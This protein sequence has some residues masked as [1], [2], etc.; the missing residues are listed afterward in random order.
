[1]AIRTYT[2]II[3][4]NVSG[5]NAPTQRHRLAEWIQK[6]YPYIC[7]LQETHFNYRDTY[8]LKVRRWKK[9]FH[10]NGNQ[11]KFGTSILISDKIDPKIK[12][13]TGVPVMAQWLT[14]QTRHHEFAGSIPGIAQWVK[15]PALL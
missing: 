6:Q 4:S 3:T 10:E 5:L 1:M 15:D 9:I 14:K 13:I 8:K 12:N 11:K 2:L 7:C